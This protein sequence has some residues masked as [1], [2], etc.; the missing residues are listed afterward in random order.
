M[1]E[2]TDGAASPEDRAAD[3]STSKPGTVLGDA[4][5]DAVF[6]GFLEAAPDAVVI[7]DREGRIVQVNS[8]TEQLFGY[9]RAE[10]VGR[11]IEVL[12]P[13]RFRSRHPGHR[14]AYFGIRTCG[15]WA[16]ASSSSGCAGTERSSRSR[17]A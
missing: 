11:P 8:Q 12:I 9:P 6:P 16:R 1:A 13:E 17:S 4:G 2:L 10:L 3:A 15:P 14:T 7:G 5:V